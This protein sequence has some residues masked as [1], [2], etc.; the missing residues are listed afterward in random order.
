MFIEAK[1]NELVRDWI[2]DDLSLIKYE[3]YPHPDFLVD[4]QSTNEMNGC[5]EELLTL[6]NANCEQS[7]TYQELINCQYVHVIIG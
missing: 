5:L 2:Y 6:L 4:V 3:C 7:Y 1:V